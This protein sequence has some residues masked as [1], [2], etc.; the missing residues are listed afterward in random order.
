M[1]RFWK[2]LTLP[3]LEAFKPNLVVEIGAKDGSNTKLLWNFCRE[4]S[5]VLHVI[6]PAPSFSKEDICD[7]K[8]TQKVILHKKLSLEVLP[9]IHNI[10]AALIDGD[11]NWYTVY[12][13]L[14]TLMDLS[15]QD[16]RPFPLVL[17][18]DVSW[19]YARRDLYY[20]PETIPTEFRNEYDRKGIIPGNT[21]LPGTYLKRFH[22]QNQSAF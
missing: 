14:K 21:E 8:E 10:D 15:R 11:H 18:H 13:E 6:D 2:S 16:K 1:Y 4:Q 12:N 7:M 5:S 20:N 3:L 19:P 22:V 9:D 17:L